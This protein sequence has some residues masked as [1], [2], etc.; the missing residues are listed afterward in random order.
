MKSHLDRSRGGKG[1]YIGITKIISMLGVL[2]L[3]E[4]TATTEK[5]KERIVIKY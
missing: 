3:N 5:K 1:G 2:A 4:S